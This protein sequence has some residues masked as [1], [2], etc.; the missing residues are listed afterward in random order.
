MR[1]RIIEI[2]VILIIVFVLIVYGII[3]YNSVENKA[4]RTIREDV[5]AWFAT[6]NP[7][8]SKTQSDKEIII[9]I[10]F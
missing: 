2:M 9:K 4:D 8:E 10:I 6:S 7:D 1:S 5:M 3:R